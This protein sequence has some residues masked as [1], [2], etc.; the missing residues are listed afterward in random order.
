M[1]LFRLGTINHA[2]GY[3]LNKLLKRH[4]VGEKHL[5]L[6]FLEEGYPPKHRHLIRDAIDDLKREGVFWFRTREPKAAQVPTRP[7]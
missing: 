2:K 1:P 4:L 6:G 7:S 3:V 5:P